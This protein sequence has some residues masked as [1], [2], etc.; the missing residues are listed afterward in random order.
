MQR[1][2]RLRPSSQ[3]VKTLLTWYTGRGS[4]GQIYVPW[5]EEHKTPA[6]TS[7][8]AL[9]VEEGTH[10]SR[11]FTCLALSNSPE[12]GHGA[13]VEFILISAGELNALRLIFAMMAASLLYRG[14]AD[15]YRSVFG[16][17]YGPF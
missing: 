15:L 8:R 10:E 6:G 14:A 11:G 13:H 3:D 4:S 5:H 12:V 7:R 9:S 17:G 2:C 1:L 16:I